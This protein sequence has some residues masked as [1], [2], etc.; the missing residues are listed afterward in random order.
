MVCFQDPGF[1]AVKDKPWQMG[2][3]AVSPQGSSCLPGWNFRVA[4][5]GERNPGGATQTEVL[6]ICKAKTQRGERTLEMAEAPSAW[7]QR[8]DQHI[9]VSRAPEATEATKGTSWKDWRH[10][11]FPGLGTLPGPTNQTRKTSQV[12]E[13]WAH[14]QKVLV[15]VMGII[16]HRIT[17]A[18]GPSRH[19]TKARTKRIKLFASN[20][21]ASQNKSQEH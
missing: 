4:A 14:N 18:L 1:Q 7:Q 15:S 21:T 17:V 3:S 10:Q 6:R 13:H 12:T 2:N 11:S 20:S 16:S 9:C 19:I 5:Q 8:T